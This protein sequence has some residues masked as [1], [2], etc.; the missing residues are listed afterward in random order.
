LR[1]TIKE[2]SREHHRRPGIK[3]R[4]RYKEAQRRYKAAVALNMVKELGLSI[5]P[6]EDV[7]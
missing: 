3:E 6:M 7:T 1:E 4:R 2:K 5:P